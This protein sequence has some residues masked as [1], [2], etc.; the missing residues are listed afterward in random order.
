MPGESA[1]ARLPF[2]GEDGV[3][4]VVSR[5]QPGRPA[6]LVYVRSFDDVNIWRIETSAP[7]V[8]TSSP[9]VVSISST[10]LDTSPQFSPDSRRVAFDSSRSGE[11]EI[12]L[13]DPDGSNAIQLTSMGAIPGSP[14]WSPDGELITFHSNPEGQAE[15]YVVPAAGGKP[16]G[17]WRAVA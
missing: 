14:R 1:P 3:M 16:G 2:V 5:P 9:P 17:R 8:P 11:M 4:P 12:W 6:R 13:A 7:G 15:V 10:R